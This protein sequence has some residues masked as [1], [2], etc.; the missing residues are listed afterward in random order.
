MGVNPLTF[1]PMNQLNLALLLL[2]VAAGTMVVMHGYAHVWR[3]GKIKGTAAWFG[4]MGMRPPLVQ[5]WMA[6]I[7]EMGS[8]ALLILGLFTP[9]AAAGLLGVMTVAFLIAHRKN[10][11][12]IYNAGQ[13]WE[14]VA[15]IGAIAVAVGTVGA[16]AW[17]LDHKLDMTL[18]DGWKG[19]GV[20][21]FGGIGGAALLLATCWRPVEKVA[22]SK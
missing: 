10:G 7:T 2:R 19:L 20:T 1:Q 14:Y 17:S 8:G 18:F 6:S 9:L 5:A 16:G 11:F 3:G 13:G 4:S 22:S 12:F 15:I 21:L